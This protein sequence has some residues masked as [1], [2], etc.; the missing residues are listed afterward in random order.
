MKDTFRVISDTFNFQVGLKQRKKEYV[1]YATPHLVFGVVCT[2]RPEI[3]AMEIM[4][5]S[6][7]SC[8]CTVAD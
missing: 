8:L 4:E 5:C 2:S 6:L 7:N 1:K 3:E